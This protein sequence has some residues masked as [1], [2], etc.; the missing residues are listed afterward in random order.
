MM[1]L[2]RV[3]EWLSYS[4]KYKFHNFI[5]LVT[6]KGTLKFDNGFSIKL[7]RNN[8]RSILGLYYFC[9]KYGVEIRNEAGYW[10]YQNGVLTTPD[11]LNFSI[12]GFDPSIFFETFINDYHFIYPDLS[13]KIILNAGGFVGETALYYAS[14]G[15]IV[16]SFEPDI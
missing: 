9:L 15:G 3:F 7:N 2:S 12:D 14:K 4:E 11:G 8:F 13:D 16:Y 6:K 5:S 1:P 10:G